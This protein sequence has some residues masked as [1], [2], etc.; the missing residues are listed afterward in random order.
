M[1]TE[2]VELR[3]PDG[4]PVLVRAE[5]VEDVKWGVLDGPADAGLGSH[6][7]ELVTKTV[8]GVAG[9]LH[10]ALQAVCPDQVSVEIGFDLAI[11]GSQLVALVASGDVHAALRVRLEWGGE[12]ARN[13]DGAPSDYEAAA[14]S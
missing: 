5:L 2:V 12:S 8:R 7:F 6:S 3:L 14:S 10:K 11:K 9:E 1:S 4:I 13:A